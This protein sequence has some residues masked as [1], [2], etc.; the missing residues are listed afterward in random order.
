MDVLF[1]LQWEAGDVLGELEWEAG[2]SG[3]CSDSSARDEH[4]ISDG[5]GVEALAIHAAEEAV[6]GIGVGG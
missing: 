2:S 3:R 4:R 6:M 5:L 1:F